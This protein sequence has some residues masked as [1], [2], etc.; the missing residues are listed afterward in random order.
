MLKAMGK[1]SRNNLSEA[2][3]QAIVSLLRAR[4]ILSQEE[5]CKNLSVSQPTFSRAV[6][7]LIPDQILRFGKARRT[8][9]GAKRV[10]SDVGSKV[11]VVVIGDNGGAKNKGDLYAIFPSGFVWVA[12]GVA[13]IQ[14]FKY[15][16]YFLDDLRPQGFLGRLVPRLHPELGYP[17]DIRNWSGDH[18]LG[19]LVRHGTDSMG[20]VLLGDR[21]IALYTQAKDTATKTRVSKSQRAEK[22]PQYADR[23]L[24]QGSPG[25]SAAGEQPKFSCHVEA[26]R[27]KAK[28]VLVK[29]SP[30]VSESVGRRVGD[31]LICESLAHEILRDGGV[32]AAQSQIFEYKKQIFLEVERFDRTSKDGRRGIISLNALNLEFAAN[33]GSWTAVAEELVERKILPPASLETIARADL[34]GELIANSDRH[35]GNLS[36]FF[37]DFNVGELTPIYDMLP[38]LYMPHQGQILSRHYL[39]EPPKISQLA[40]WSWA[41]RLALEYWNRI[42]TDSRVSRNFQK[43]AADNK[44]ILAALK[45]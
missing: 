23:A 45:Y 27:Q 21:A 19:Y 15:L 40:Y 25:S 30:P 16:P 17:P 8:V 1:T 5:I 33:T 24:E 43:I 28:S 31:L 10:V 22:Y 14:S 4:G 41:Q 42:Q 2:L 6:Q 11:G 26:A 44:K 13:A 37:D 34:F 18:T 38:M 39:P 29:F 12:Q 3:G 32:P 20:Q 35:N 7:V 36:F 9:Y